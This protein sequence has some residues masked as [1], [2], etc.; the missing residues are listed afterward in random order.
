MALSKEKARGLRYRKPIVRD[1]NFFTIQQELAEIEEV[2]SDVRWYFDD[3]TLLNALD[4]DEDETRE[5][6]MMFGD[7]CA[8]VEQ[9]QEDLHNE[10]VPTYFDDFFVAASKDETIFGWDSFEGDYM[11][12]GSSYE[13]DLARR[14]SRKRMV[15]LTKDE[16]MEGAQICFRIFRSYIGLKYRYDCLKAALDILRGENSCYLQ[17]VK[18]IDEVYGAADADG[19]YPYSESYRKLDKLAQSMPDMAWLQ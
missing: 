11:G 16:F 15:R 9:M 8:E 14:E 17:L 2:C 3:E 13:E 7:L 19:M 6:Q 5:F 1:V 12:L 10:Y 4:G 18:Q